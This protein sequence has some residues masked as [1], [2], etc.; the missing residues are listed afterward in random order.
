MQVEKLPEAEATR[1]LLEQSM[2]TERIAKFERERANQ[3][4]SALVVSQTHR[5]NDGDYRTIAQTNNHKRIG[6]LS[7]L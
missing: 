6:S 2:Q 1:L 5:A 7:P 3:N 4:R